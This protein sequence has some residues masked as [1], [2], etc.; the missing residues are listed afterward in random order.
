MAIDEAEIS[1]EEAEL[2][3]LEENLDWMM[4]KFT[5]FVKEFL[6]A[7]ADQ[8]TT[9]TPSQIQL[10]FESLERVLTWEDSLSERHLDE[11]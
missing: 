11:S 10:A 9:L 8:S 2:I 1:D 7:L 3:W 4:R 5:E 6:R